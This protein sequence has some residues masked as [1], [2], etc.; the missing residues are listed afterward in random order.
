MR[1]LILFIAL[2]SA[3]AFA[4]CPNIS[5]N[6][7]CSDGNETYQETFSTAVDGNG[8]TIYTLDDTQII[9]DGQPR[10]TPGTLMPNGKYTATCDTTNKVLVHAEGPFQW[11]SDAGY[12]KF[13]MSAYMSG[14]V[15]K[16]DQHEDYLPVQGAERTS[17]TALTCT[18]AP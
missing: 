17:D 8:V 16:I 2:T 10:P 6:F 12:L 11:G 3:P 4:A 14:T 7:N 13:D 9:T 15:L 1:Q 18:P 5:G